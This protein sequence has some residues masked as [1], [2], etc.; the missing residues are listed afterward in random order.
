MARDSLK[1]K[2]DRRIKI[3]E[4]RTQ[5]A[6]DSSDQERVQDLG[7]DSEAAGHTSS[8]PDPSSSD[9]RGFGTPFSSGILSQ[10]A[11]GNLAVDLDDVSEGYD[12]YHGVK[13]EPEDDW[14]KGLEESESPTM[15][16]TPNIPTSN[17]STNITFESDDVVR[18]TLTATP[19][20][21]KDRVSVLKG[22]NVSTIPVKSSAGP[23]RF[24]RVTPTRAGMSPRGGR[25]LRTIISPA[26]TAA[27]DETPPATTPA[28]KTT[29][30]PSTGGSGAGSGRRKRT[31]S[32]GTASNVSPRQT[33]SVAKT[34]EVEVAGASPTVNPVV[35]PALAH[36][37]QR[38]A[39][40]KDSKLGKDVKV[41]PRHIPKV[42]DFDWELFDIYPAKDVD[43]K[44]AAAAIPK[45]VLL[46]DFW[47]YQMYH[48][49]V[50]D[51]N[52]KHPTDFTKHVDYR[53]GAM[54]LGPDLNY[55]DDEVDDA[56]VVLSPTIKSLP[57][58]KGAI[59][60]Q[61]TA[62]QDVNSNPSAAPATAN[63]D[64][65]NAPEAQEDEEE[66]FVDYASLQLDTT[67]PTGPTESLHQRQPYAS[68]AVRR[69]QVHRYCQGGEYP[70]VPGMCTREMHCRA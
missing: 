21:S 10:G 32:S 15:I 68:A 65:P 59:K 60:A 30:A 44:E 53:S 16:P 57:W 47:A 39:F 67:Q 17:I 8:Y 40:T 22:V 24:P 13:S 62:I 56:G 58:W 54:R 46:S 33:R 69:P 42:T 29:P 31:E 27:G 26:G 50:Q 49:E 28:P 41:L 20:S 45:N 51:R 14:R 34:T 37:S 11:S 35:N 9:R 3:L 36:M 1:R 52:A 18:G 61:A 2:E 25:G 63:T 19:T 4:E 6:A 23:S 70:T 43:L 7:E 55:T 48:F 66:I 12:G 5:E 64:A 38:R